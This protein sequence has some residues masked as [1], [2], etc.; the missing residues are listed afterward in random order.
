MIWIKYIQDGLSYQTRYTPSNHSCPSNWTG[1]AITVGGGYI[2]GDVYEFAAKHNSIAV[3]GDDSVRSHLSWAL[4]SRQANNN[5][6]CRGYW[7]IY[8]G[9][10]S[11]PD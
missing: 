1:G 3:G 2:W 4:A 8:S 9:R 6:D 10:R 5:T 7:R 11:W